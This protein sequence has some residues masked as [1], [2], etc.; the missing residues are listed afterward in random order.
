MTSLPDPLVEACANARLIDARA[1]VIADFA[2]DISAISDPTAV[3]PEE[4][5]SFMNS[6]DK[7]VEEL[8]AETDAFG[9]KARFGT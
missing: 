2:K 3:K 5:T 6:L 9:S 8:K 1:R 4:W 7:L